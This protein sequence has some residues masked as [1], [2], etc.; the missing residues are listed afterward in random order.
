[1]LVFENSVCV[2][3]GTPQGFDVSTLQLV[4]VTN[5][6]GAV[7]CANLDLAA[8]NWLAPAPGGL[9]LCCRL[10]RTRPDDDDLDGL[11]AF[12]RT[13]AAK[14]R[15]VYQ[16]LDL[17]LPVVPKAQDDVRG[18]AFDLLSS[19][20][21]RVTTGHADGVVTIDLAE[22]HDAHR[23]TLRVEMAEP[24]RTLLGHV[25][26][27]VGHYYWTVLVEGNGLLPIPAGALEK[28]RELFGDERVDYGEA[29]QRH[30]SAGPPA[31]WG[32][33]SVSAYATAHPWEDWAE[34]FAHYLHIRDTLQTAGAYGL[35]VT[36]PE[37]GHVDGTGLAATP[38]RQDLDDVP[39]QQLIDTWL[40]LT[41]ALN[42]VNRSMGAGDLYPFVLSGTVIRKLGFVHE[43]AR[44]LHDQ[45]ASA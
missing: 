6:S 7:P 34:T 37:G 16:L 2:T 39:V 43:L 26:H 44:S 18:L 22:G 5:G 35:I 24:Y 29:L 28:F 11:A 20:F 41:Y 15:L 19:A 31:G 40:P 21:T 9:C 3:C 36:G 10:T 8:C 14:R 42:A 45:P 1:L 23:E 33:W 4:P 38:G 30:Y 12:A 32:A 13:E 27:E 17:H 25:R